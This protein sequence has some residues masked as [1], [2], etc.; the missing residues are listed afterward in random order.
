[1]KYRNFV[2]S[3]FVSLLLVIGTNAF[4]TDYYRP[5]V[6]TQDLTVMN[7]PVFEAGLGIETSGNVWYVD[8]G[9]SGTAAGTSWTNASLT[10]DAAI[11]LATAANGDL[12]RV[13]AGHAEAYTAANGFD[14]DKAGI[15]IVHEGSIGAQATYTYSDTDATIAVGAA[16]CR[17]FGGR[18]LAGISGVVI[19]IA[20]EAGGDDFELID[21]VFPEPTTSSW[22]FVDTIDLAAGAD[23]VKIIR[24]V[25]FTADAVGAAHFI[26]AGNGVNNNLSVITPYLYGEYSVSAIWSDTVDLE[27]LIQGGCITN[28]TDGQHAIEFTGAALGSIK[29]ILVRTDVQTTAVDP[30]SLTL[31]NVVW[32]DDEVADSTSSP[33]VLGADGPATIGQI[34]STTTDSVHGKIGTD[35]EMGDASLYDQYIADQ[36]D[37]DAI[38]YNQEKVISVSADEITADLFDVDGGAILIK[39]IVGYVSAV[40]GSNATTAQLIVDRDD[41]TT[42]TEFTTAVAITDDP[43]GTVYAFSDAN[44]AVL[45]PLE[46]G[47]TGLST[48]MSSWFCPEGMIEQLMSADPGGAATDHIT[49]YMTYVP[50]AAGI[51]VTAQ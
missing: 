45:T 49:W 36:I 44:P 26:D 20:V 51:T 43:V 30:G 29:D 2:V 38:L 12:I 41:S 46:P 25:Q 11:N 6:K 1:M 39:S 24:P 9:A 33:V 28:L 21:A 7:V 17:I 50:L 35:A 3:V 34:D 32:D 14:L 40:V 15:T 27:V 13:A 5:W 22:E 16:N 47:A 8:S 31:S 18:Y 37:L 10:V 19:G 4:A 23:G 48:L 42:D